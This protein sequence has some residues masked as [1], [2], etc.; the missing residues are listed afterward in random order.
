MSHFTEQTKSR[1]LGLKKLSPVRRLLTHLN[2]AKHQTQSSDDALFH[3][4]CESPYSTMSEK[5]TNISVEEVVNEK[6][7]PY[8]HQMF[9][10]TTPTQSFSALQALPR[11]M[12]V[13]IA[14]YL[15][16]VNRACLALTCRHTHQV[17]GRAL[18]LAAYERYKFLRRLERDG[19]WPSKILCGACSKFHLP[20]LDRNWDEHEGPRRCIQY[21]NGYPLQYLESPY[22]PRQVHY[23]IV[24]AITRS[25]RFNSRLYD[26]NFLSSK[27]QY[28]AGRV[29]ITSNVS[30]RHYKG[31]IVLKTELVLSAGKLAYAWEN[32]E[33]LEKMLQ[34]STKLENV[35][36]HVKWTEVLP[37]LFRLQL[38][39][40]RKSGQSC[41]GNHTGK[42]CK[43][44]N[45]D[46]HECLWTHSQRYYKISLVRQKGKSSEMNSVVLTSWK[47]LGQCTNVFDDNWTS[48]MKTCRSDL[49]HRATELYDVARSYENPAKGL[50]DFE[51]YP[52]L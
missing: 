44:S 40:V 37:F 9:Q 15:S 5:I 30:A 32:M 21:G 18:R 43:V 38:P 42:E 6:I 12:L 48:H 36:Q 31:A 49:Q 23:D 7:E 20:R 39:T 52:S 2:S 16:S 19:M 13:K 47:N 1:S 8:E 17:L 34:K 33:K 45:K 14:T 27:D 29:K 28:T 11:N 4:H 3:I 50:F 26:I 41:L 25:H 35:C 24:A 22:L 46:L 10:S 51:Y